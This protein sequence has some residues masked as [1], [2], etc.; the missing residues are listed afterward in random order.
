MDNG[1]RI[2]RHPVLRVVRAI[3]LIVLAILA[4]TGIFLWT[5]SLQ[6]KNEQIEQRK[7][8]AEVLREKGETG[9]L[10]MAGIPV[11]NIFYGDNGV[12]LFQGDM[13]TYRYSADELQNISVY[14]S[15]NQSV[16]HITTISQGSV[17]TFLEA[18]PEKGTGSGIVISKDGYILTNA[19]VVNGASELDIR[20]YDES[21]HKGILVGVDQEND[22]AVLKITLPENM[23]LSPIKFGT[24][25]DLKVGQ[26]LVAIGNPFGYD[27]TM[28]IGMVSGLGRPVRTD[29]NTVI[30]GMIQTDAAI[31]PGNS[32]GPLL[33]G[34]GEMVGICTT[35]HSTTGGSQGIGFAIP[36]DTAISVIP[37]LI[38]HGKVVRGWLDITMVQLESRIVEY[39]QL[40]V[41]NGLLVSQVVEGGKAEKGGL[42]GGTD[43]VQYGSSIIFLGGDVIVEVNGEK[44]SEY[45][46]LYSALVNTHP[47][48]VVPVKAIRKGELKTLQIE[49]INRP[50]K[51]EWIVR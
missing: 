23:V 47:G 16:V 42:K 11:N 7:A 45:S 4:A 50:E 15:S 9:L 36:V 28:T 43:K 33:N 24:A 34:R 18:L 13:A 25:T 49:L 40:G 44:I 39:A 21:T 12:T 29:T 2:N 51:M 8:L 10:E 35:I 1:H 37:D 26:K 22:L 41:S 6:D 3:G 5:R 48:D 17:N 38:K 30:N 27:R 46:D 19:H 31:N 20:L 32:G 14:E